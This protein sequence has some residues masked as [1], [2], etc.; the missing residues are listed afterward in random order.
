MMMENRLKKLMNEE[1]RLLKQ[2]NLALKNQDFADEVANRRMDDFNGRNDWLNHKEERRLA[3]LALNTDRRE[4]NK[5]NITNSKHRVLSTN[6]YS[7][8]NAG[9]HTNSNNGTINTYR[10]TDLSNKQHNA[11]SMY[12]HRKEASF[13]SKYDKDAYLESIQR[14]N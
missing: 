8:Q 6:C 7:R 10:R 12:S 1:D 3:A 5:M 13:K 9:L 11:S 2:C 14:V 4:A